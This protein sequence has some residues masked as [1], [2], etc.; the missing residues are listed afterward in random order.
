MSNNKL[1]HR[2]LSIWASD[3]GTVGVVRTTTQHH[4]RWMIRGMPVLYGVHIHTATK[5][6]LVA[7]RDCRS[8]MGVAMNVDRG[9]EVIMNGGDR[10]SEEYNLLLLGSE[11]NNDRRSIRVKDHHHHAMLPPLPAVSQ[12]FAACRII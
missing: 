6:S 7:R 2:R 8:Q 9:R 3:E 11:N 5:G 1:V 4:R 10:R 12:S